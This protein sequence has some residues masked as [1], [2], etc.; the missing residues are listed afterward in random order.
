M[1]A[2]NR[3]LPASVFLSLIHEAV[4]AGLIP[5]RVLLGNDASEIRSRAGYC[6]FLRRLIY[7]IQ[8]FDQNVMK[9]KSPFQ[10]LSRDTKSMIVVFFHIIVYAIISFSWRF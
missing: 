5:I 2:I 1:N 10:D 6:A 4:I 9:S 3:R 7:K 8:N